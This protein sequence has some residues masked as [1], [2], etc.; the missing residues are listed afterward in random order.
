MVRRSLILKIFLYAVAALVATFLLAFGASRLLL[1]HGMGD[2]YR[3]L[4]ADYTRFFARE[5]EASFQDGQPSQVRLDELQRSLHVRLDYFP[6]ASG[7][8]LPGGLAEQDWALERRAF[9]PDNVYWVRIAPDGELQGALRVIFLPPRAAGAVAG[10]FAGILVLAFGLLIIPPLY[11]WIIRPLR[12]MVETAHR[13]GRDLDTP[14]AVDRKDEFG[15]LERA[16]EAMRRQIQ[17]MLA[18]K[19]RLLTDI[20]HEL[21]GPLSRMAVALP[22]ARA[23]GGSSPYLDHIERNMDAMDVLIGELL[24]LSRGMI[25]PVHDQEPLDLAELAQALV[26]ERGLI[27]EQRAL[28]CEERLEPAPLLGDRQLLERAMGNL[29]DN[30]L[31]YGQ[32]RIRVETRREGADAIFAVSDEGPGIPEADLPHVFEPFYRP[33]TS[34]SRESGG[35]G[36]GLAI[37]KAVAE[38]HGGSASLAA[39]EGEGTRAIL[40]F[41]ARLGV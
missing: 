35:T 37:V 15:D 10:T 38:S 1:E 23:D 28:T 25:P 5:V 22:L 21:R 17:R 39:R 4:G 8:V 2:T 16:F 24:A 9:R 26:D 29:L 7:S 32:G 30:A 18:Q 36:L 3:E 31:K 41:P 6:L 19:E 13:L 33:D 14:V 27:L 12:G 34:R 11:F 20:S 40:R